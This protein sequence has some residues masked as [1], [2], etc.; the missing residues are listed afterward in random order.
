MHLN[1]RSFFKETVTSCSTLFFSAKAARQLADEKACITLLHTNDMHSQL[2]PFPMDG[3]RWQGRGGIQARAALIQEIRKTT[4]QVLLFDSGDFFQPSPL[5]SLYK[6]EPEIKAMS[7]LR[8]DAVTLGEHDFDAGIDNLSHQLQHASFAVVN[9][10]YD[11]SATSMKERVVPYKTF[12]KGIIKAGV[13]GIGIDL[14][15]QTQ[16]NLYGNTKCLDPI[17]AANETANVLRTKEYCN[18]VIC[19]SHLGD[20]YFDMGIMSDERLAQQSYDIDVILGA[21]THRFFDA[22]RVYKNRRNSDVVV[23]QAGWGG[24]ALGRLDIN[25]SGGGKKNL[26]HTNTVI[27]GEKT[28]D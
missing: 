1:R 16:A 18:L 8:Y 7:L 14:K 2:Q 20:K 27:I 12:E 25:I 10:N 5:F 19:L 4:A 23:H 21:H 6:G 13:F 24:L 11:F 26:V 15:G 9:C 17:A 3:G 22:P 28:S